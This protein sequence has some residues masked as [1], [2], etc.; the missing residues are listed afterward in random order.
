MDSLV[1][2]LHC[3]LISIVGIILPQ[4]F[5]G[6]KKRHLARTFWE[7]FSTCISEGFKFL[8]HCVDLEEGSET[9]IF[10]LGYAA[11]A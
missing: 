5:C 7:V 9:K 1:V 2:Q 10:F 8:C 6:K 11:M 3:N 4:I